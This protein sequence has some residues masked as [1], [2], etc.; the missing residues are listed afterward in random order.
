MWNQKLVIR[1]ELVSAV[2]AKIWASPALVPG[3][4]MAPYPTFVSVHPG[5]GVP[6]KAKVTGNEVFCTAAYA[7][8][9]NYNR[10][11]CQSNGLVFD[12]TTQKCG[13]PVPAPTRCDFARLAG[14]SDQGSCQSHGGVW[15]SGDQECGCP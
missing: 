5:G 11:A 13:C 14:L 15:K 2:M 4:K 9:F 8:N 3:V 10:I 1:Q 7:A 6:A 12:Y